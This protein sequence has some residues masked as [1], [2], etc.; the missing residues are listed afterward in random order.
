MVTEHT[1]T[2]HRHLGHWRMVLRLRT[3]EHHREEVQVVRQVAAGVRLLG[4]GGVQELTEVVEH[5][6]IQGNV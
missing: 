1:N 6:P 3:V 4:E 2:E 5:I